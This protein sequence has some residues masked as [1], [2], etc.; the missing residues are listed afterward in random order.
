MATPYSQTEQ[1]QGVAGYASPYVQNMLGAAQSQLFNTDASGNLTGLRGYTPYSYNA[2]DYFAGFTPLQQQA[3]QGI[4]NLSLPSSFGQAMGLTGETY[5]NLMGLGGQA[6][7]AGQNYAQM[8]TNPS[9]VGS[10]MNPYLMNSL[11]P[12]MALLGQQQAQ[13]ANQLAGQATQAGAFGGSRYG[14]QQGLQNQAN[15]LAMSNLVGQGFNNA[16][17]Q[18]LQNMQYGANLGLQGQQAAAGMYGQGLNA[19][20]QLANIG[21]QA[22]GAQQGILNAQQQEIGRA[23]V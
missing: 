9:A 14:L 17:N 5:G 3:Q 7:Q 6:A 12:Q 23:H 20:N 2:A 10:Y 11:A 8:A 21:N 19:A 18:A 16:Y 15:Q 13:Q 22:L 4:A 1:Q